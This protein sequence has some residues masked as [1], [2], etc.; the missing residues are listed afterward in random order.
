MNINNDP[1]VAELQH[2]A[3][4]IAGR[5]E[6]IATR[7]RELQQALAGRRHRRVRPP[8]DARCGLRATS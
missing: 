3:R 8:G 4:Q 5:L 7:Q 6:A 2:K 1:I